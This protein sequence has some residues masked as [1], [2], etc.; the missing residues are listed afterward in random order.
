MSTAKLELST[1]TAPVGGDDGI[2]SCVRRQRADTVAFARSLDEAA[3]AGPTRCSEWSVRELLAH[4]CDTTS[5]FDR[6]FAGVDRHDFDPN[7]DPQKMVDAH[8][9]DTPEQVLDRLEQV[10]ARYV[11]RVDSLLQ[12]GDSTRVPWLY[13]NPL[14]WRLLAI[15]AFWDEW[16][17]ERDLRLPREPH[18]R[19]GDGETR[20]AAAYGLML[21]GLGPQRVGLDICYE[22]TFGGVGGGRY[23][24]DVAEGDVTVTVRAGDGDGVD[25]ALAVDSMAGR[26]PLPTEFME[27]EAA[28]LGAL[29]LVGMTIRGDLGEDS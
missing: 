9:S 20:L 6:R 27:G 3:Y 16:I 15:H 4:L 13:A 12:S 19:S 8:A 2:W 10:S 17:H 21:C 1:A 18:H 25:A 22:T 11:E 28:T 7:S 5:I 14:D 29:S 26:G 24:L 23:R